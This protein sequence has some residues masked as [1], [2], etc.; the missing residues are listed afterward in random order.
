MPADIKAVLNPRAP[1]EKKVPKPAHPRP[2]G[3][4]RST[5]G[6]APDA[7]VIRKRPEGDVTPHKKS[8]DS[9]HSIKKTESGQVQKRPEAPPGL[10]RPEGAPIQ[11]RP[12]NETPNAYTIKKK[13][14]VSEREKPPLGQAEQ[15]LNRIR[16]TV[17]TDRQPMETSPGDTNGRGGYGALNRRLQEPTRGP[18]PTQ[19]QRGY[20]GQQQQPDFEEVT[21][22]FS[23]DESGY[24][25]QPQQTKL[26]R[27]QPQRP[28]PHQQHPP[29]SQSQ[30]QYQSQPQQ[31]HPQHSQSHFQQQ[32]QQ[33][34]QSLQSQQQPH[35]LKPH[36]Q[37][38]QM[39][40]FPQQTGPM[41]SHQMH[42]PQS[43]Q[44]PL[45]GQFH[46]QPSQRTGPG[47]ESQG[48]QQHHDRY[49][50]PFPQ[51]GPSQMQQ[52][53]YRHPG[54]Q[55][56]QQPPGRGPQLKEGNNLSQIK[57][58]V[59]QSLKKEPDSSRPMMETEPSPLSGPTRVDSFPDPRTMRK[60]SETPVYDQG[61]ALVFKEV[62]QSLKRELPRSIKGK[63]EYRL[64]RMGMGNLSGMVG[65]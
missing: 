17:K 49:P 31:L 55:D 51:Q 45:Q 28:F 21:Q 12:E 44:F 63:Y 32:Q 27:D 18:A 33:Q 23:D 41:Q 29:Q 13:K 11:R 47:S 46:G 6:A 42:H 3:A 61:N 57:K 25:P 4:P 7:D 65:R 37:S 16:K 38:Q 35:L 5:S 39:G 34:P 54:G 40:Q 60:V 43:H 2:E 64:N 36:P 15:D 62:L 50:F 20:F 56:Q 1:T 52:Q 48:Q 59:E 10:K 9:E 8:I 14:G 58:F 53:Q 30:F 22:V 24:T 26:P 19:G